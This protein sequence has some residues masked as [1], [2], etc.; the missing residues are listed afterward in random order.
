MSSI[1]NEI[2]TKDISDNIGTNTHQIKFQGKLIDCEERKKQDL[3]KSNVNNAKPSG[4]ARGRQ[5]GW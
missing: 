5:L 3:S 4:A 2:R 1:K